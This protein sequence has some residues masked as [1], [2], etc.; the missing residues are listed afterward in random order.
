MTRERF[1]AAMATLSV[2][3]GGAVDDVRLEVYYRVLGD[4]TD[5]EF[6]MAATKALRSCRFLP[7]PAELLELA[8]PRHLAA[9][10]GKVYDQIR[11]LADYSER[12]GSTW[13]VTKI[14][15]ALGEAA[16]EAFQAAG[17][18][19]AF[20]SGD[21]VWTRK[22][23]V[24]AY[25]THPPHEAPPALPASPKER[26]QIGKVDRETDPK[27]LPFVK[28]IGNMPRLKEP[29]PERKAIVDD[30]ADRAQR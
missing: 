18:S 22:A 1:A 15:L 5:E 2:L 20:R 10:A 4:L 23:F 14:R 3:P 27:V 7:T 11:D 30:A 8:R 12:L 6:E 19:D 21:P 28:S 17:G 16:A 9:E 25:T 29:A 24:E 13:T 26:R